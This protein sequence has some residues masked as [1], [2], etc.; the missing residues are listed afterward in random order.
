MNL[1]K[2]TVG[3]VTLVIMTLSIA[4]NMRQSRH[5]FTIL[6]R[7]IMLN[8]VMTNGVT[9]LQQQLRLTVANAKAEPS[10]DSVGDLRFRQRR[11][12]A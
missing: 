8:V 5:I 11:R 1:S 6:L 12:N 2:R 4:T 7:V 3:I 9:P 10:T